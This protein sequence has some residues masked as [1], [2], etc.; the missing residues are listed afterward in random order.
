M[1]PPSNGITPEVIRDFMPPYHLRAD[2]LEATILA[3]PRPPPDALATWREERL[4]RLVEEIIAFRPADAAQARIAA[5]I[6]VVRELADTLANRA[7]AEGVPAEQIS[8][9]S[10]SAG[11]MVQT[12]MGLERVLVR[13]QKLPVAFFGT[14]V[15]DEVDIAALDAVWCRKP[16]K[17][18]APPEPAAEAG[19][20]GRCAGGGAA[21]DDAAPAPVGDAAAVDA[22]PAPRGEAALDDAAPTPRG[23]AARAAPGD[24][25]P[26]EPAPNQRDPAPPAP[27]AELS[28]VV[29]GAATV[30]GATVVTGVPTTPEA[31]PATGAPTL[32]CPTGT[33]GPAWRVGP[34]DTA[35]C[36]PPPSVTAP[37]VAAPSVPPSC[38]AAPCIPDSSIADGGAAASPG[39]GSGVA[40]KA[41]A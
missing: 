35:P 27:D 11:A 1:K 9:L 15:R 24:T 34:A 20:A 41:S 4:V 23:E 2:L 18:P 32:S 17:Q 5:Q 37:C 29:T 28:P 3:L 13:H 40:A 7:H 8:R 22:A 12:A 38:V 26:P 30:A 16:V 25:D 21:A 33:E 14:V 39:L 6:L 31:P 36:V 19:A 10:R